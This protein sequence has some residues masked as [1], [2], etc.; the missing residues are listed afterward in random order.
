MDD[1]MLEAVRS[2]DPEREFIIVITR[3]EGGRWYTCKVRESADDLVAR[4]LDAV[5]K[6]QLRDVQAHGDGLMISGYLNI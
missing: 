1:E 5:R 6:G 4:A 3:P 2:Y